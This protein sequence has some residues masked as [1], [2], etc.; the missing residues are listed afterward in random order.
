MR[1]LLVVCCLLVALVACKRSEFTESTFTNA[2]VLVI[3]IDTLRADHLS[4][5]GYPKPTSPHIDALAAEGVLFSHVSSQAP[6]TLPSFASIF[7]GLLPSVHR[8]GEGLGWSRTRLDSKVPTL[9][10][11]LHKA[12]WRTGTFVSN[13]FAGES[14]GLGEGFDEKFQW[15]DSAAAVDAATQFLRAHAKERF[16]AFVHTID[17]HHPYSPPPDDAKPFLDPEYQGPVGA[18]YMDFPPPP[19]FTDA[20]RRQVIGL[21]DGE[22][23][24]SDRYVGQLID[25]LRDLGVLDRTIVVVVSDHGEELFDHQFNGHGHT[26]FEELLHVP[27]VIRFPDGRWT[28]RVDAQVAAMDLFPTILDALGL[29]VPPKLQGESR[30]PLIRGTSGA[31]G[32]DL[33]LS[34]FVFFA[35]EQ[36]AARRDDFKLIYTPLNSDTKAFDLK[37]DPTEQVDVAKE[38]PRDVAPLRVVLERELIQRLDGFYLVGRSGAAEHRLHVRVQSASPL[39]GARLVEG[40]EGDTLTMSDDGRTADATFLLPPPPK[41]NIQFGDEDML[42][43][44]VDGTEPVTITADVDGQP[45][46]AGTFFLGAL[47]VS[48]S[49]P[50]PW[51]F[52]PNDPRLLI[53][54]PPALAVA[55]TGEV[56]MGL[57]RVVRPAPPAATLDEKTRESLRQLGYAD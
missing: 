56:R 1:Q 4:C 31:H 19:K 41:V 36:K 32:S 34:E 55:E 42:H 35:P 30:M 27:L 16:F 48:A 15:T 52:S 47:K 39:V 21:Y 12:G 51:S 28:K 3:G 20:D 9:A 11:E 45:V 10:T 37:T 57:Y 46:D 26:L 6:W 44:R 2:N 13:G 43:F 23:H 8:A 25:L 49:G 14:V 22:V 53:P 50:P 38:R 17:P 18:E 54:Y 40:D 5:Y 24:V 7:T 29:P 33:M